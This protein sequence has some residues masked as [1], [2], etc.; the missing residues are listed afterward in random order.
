MIHSL[1]EAV[2]YTNNPRVR[3]LFHT[4]LTTYYFDESL[5]DLLNRIKVKVSDGYELLSHP[6]SGSV[7]PGETP[8]KS[9]LLSKEPGEYDLL[10]VELIDNALERSRF[11]FRHYKLSEHAK[12]ADFPWDEQVIADFALVD[13]TLVRSAVESI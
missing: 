9:V 3:D 1:E 5:I 7:K 6:L 11:F 4:Q 13:E 8:F 12:A 2:L 10:S